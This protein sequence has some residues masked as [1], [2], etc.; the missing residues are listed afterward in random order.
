MTSRATM[1]DQSNILIYIPPSQYYSGQEISGVFIVN[2]I[3][4]IQCCDLE[5]QFKG[6][7]LIC[8]ASNP[9]TP[10]KTHKK[11]LQNIIIHYSSTIFKWD[12]ELLPGKYK[13]PFQFCVPPDL[14][15]SFHYRSSRLQ[16]R[17]V[18]EIHVKL[19]TP[20]ETYKDKVEVCI[21]QR[22]DI[23]RENIEIAKSI[24][25]VTWGCLKKGSVHAR[26]EWPQD[27]YEANQD[28]ECAVEIDNSDSSLEI[29][30]LSLVMYSRLKL[31]GYDRD[32]LIIEEEILD[33]NYPI[34]LNRGEKLIGSDMAKLKFPISSAEELLSQ[35]H[36]TRGKS[37]E[38][39]FCIQL[40]IRT[41]GKYMRCGDKPEITLQCR[42]RPAA[43][44]PSDREKVVTPIDV[45]LYDTVYIQNDVGDAKA[46]SHDIKIKC[47]D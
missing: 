10:H 6:K 7:E 20:Y 43:R 38:C 12:S 17:I 15:N 14:P 1:C 34:S 24:K 25:L 33:K 21:I 9:P 23:I 22:N 13:V 32:D 37:I 46:L 5:F 4:P 26:T 3:D 11:C 28:M 18:Y 45:C 35:V 41:N 19:N 39:S 40:L 2:L 42:V 36:S 30:G 27:T 31:R 8:A 47:K 16:A 44:D 29:T